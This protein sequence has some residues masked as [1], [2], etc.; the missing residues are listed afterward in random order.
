[1]KEVSLAPQKSKEAIHKILY[2]WTVHARDALR[3]AKQHPIEAFVVRSHYYY[4]L[5]FLK[6]ETDAQQFCRITFLSVINAICYEANANWRRDLQ[7]TSNAS[8]KGK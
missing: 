4:I 5:P 2:A 1:M 7:L 6:N 8:E 3:P